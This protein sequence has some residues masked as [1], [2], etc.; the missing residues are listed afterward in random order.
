MIPITKEEARRNLLVEVRSAELGMR[1]AQQ[2]YASTP[3]AI[4]IA[5]RRLRDARRR[6]AEI[7]ES[8]ARDRE[9]KR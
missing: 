5:D 1:Q 2:H 3:A 7:D 9:D 4:D 8:L 6:L